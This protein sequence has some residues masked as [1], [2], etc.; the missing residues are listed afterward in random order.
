MRSAT[1][2]DG[3]PGLSFLQKQRVATANK[4]YRFTAQVIS[5]CQQ[6][7]VF[8]SLEN[9]ESSLFW[10]TSPMRELW[11]NFRSQISFGTFDSCVY[12]GSR[13]KATTFWS[14][15]QSV[16]DLSLRCHPSLGH[17]HA[18]WGRQASGWA[19]A[20]EAAYPPIL[21]RHWASLVTEELSR[22]GLL[23]DFGSAQG[24]VQYAAA[25]RA[26]LGLFPKATHAP[27]VVD[28]FQ[29]H[30]W[31]RLE[32]AKDRVKFVPGVRLQDPAFPK[33]STTIKVMV[34]HGVWGALVGQPVSPEVFMQRALVSQHPQTKLP[35]LPAAL[36][37]TVSLLAGRKLSELHNLRCQRLKTMCDIATELQVKEDADHAAFA[38]HMRSILKGKRIRLF[39]C[40]LQGLQYPDQSLPQDMRQGF[41][42]TGWLPDTK[43]RPSKVVPPSIA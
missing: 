34:E 21:C 43:T 13:K 32:S 42:L 2:P 31:V 16:T 1:H 22:K 35:P 11:K 38:P 24:S 15:C 23:A 14:N 39:E 17:V 4:L 12:G 20:E 9:P 10:L 6:N 5:A 18:P 29:G 30:S 33:G 37:R 3:L 27:V 28:P 41:S 19:T 26:S 25:E 7:D 8:W 36:D 40:L